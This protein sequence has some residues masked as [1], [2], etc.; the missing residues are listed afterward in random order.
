METYI[1]TKQWGGEEPA[2]K[3]WVELQVA[4]WACVYNPL[5]AESTLSRS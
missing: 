1:Y 3:M 2:G 4:V 5:S